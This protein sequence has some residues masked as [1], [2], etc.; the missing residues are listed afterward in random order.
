M[1]GGGAGL[2]EVLRRG[3]CSRGPSS[4]LDEAVKAR[5][6]A[7]AVRAALQERATEPDVGPA[8]RAGPTIS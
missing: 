1:D 8:R 7:E 4:S 5:E 2:S 3:R 6:E